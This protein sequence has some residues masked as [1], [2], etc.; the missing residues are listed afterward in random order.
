MGNLAPY[1]PWVVMIFAIVIAIIAFSKANKANS[2]VADLQKKW[3]QVSHDFT[4]V[5]SRF[6]TFERDQRNTIRNLIDREIGELFGGTIA[7]ADLPEIK[8]QE[9][10]NRVADRLIKLLADLSQTDALLT[11]SVGQ[12]VKVLFEDRASKLWKALHD[13]VTE[14]LTYEMSEEI[15]RLFDEEGYWDEVFEVIKPEIIKVINQD[16][17]EPN[18]G[19]RKHLVNYLTDRIESDL[20][21]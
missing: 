9:V 18:S 5:T 1:I 7:F 20:Q 6:D 17:S 12:I 8:K 21:V 19:I 16:L 13:A 11:E 2:Q 4:N 15:D 3:D 10:L 14:K